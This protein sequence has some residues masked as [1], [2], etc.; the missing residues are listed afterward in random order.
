MNEILA[1]IKVLKLYAWENP[2][3]KKI[4]DTREKELKTIKKNG[5]LFAIQNLNFQCS[6]L[7]IT[8]SSFT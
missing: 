3:M 8:I 6:P 7:L 5:I 4:L 1:G 2:F